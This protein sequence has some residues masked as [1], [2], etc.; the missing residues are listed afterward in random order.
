MM[1]EVC[2][3]A[4]SQ[5]GMQIDQMIYYVNV[6]TENLHWCPYEKT[7]S[8]AIREHLFKFNLYFKIRVLVGRV[9]TEVCFTVMLMYFFTLKC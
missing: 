3:T 9:C 7:A 8:G 6:K 2:P 5:W 4:T 1:L